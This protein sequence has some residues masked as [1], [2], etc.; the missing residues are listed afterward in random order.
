MTRQTRRRFLSATAGIAGG[1]AGCAGGTRETPDPVPQSASSPESD[2]PYASVY[3]ETIGSVAFVGDESGGGSGFVYRDVVVT[4]QHVV[5]DAESIGVRFEN[6]EWREAGVTATDVYA[7][8]AVLSTDV[9]AYATSLPFV[10]TIPRV[11]T[12]VL[13][14]GSPFGLES[15][16]S[17]GIISGRNRSVP[18]EQ[19][20]F[21]IPNTVQTDA[22]LD[23]GNSGG[24][25]VT[26]EGAVTGINVAGAGTS[27]G[28]AVSP[29]LARRVLPELIETGEYDH[30][31]LG[32]RLI[33]V[34]P[35]VAEA[36]G[37]EEARG[38]FVVETTD[39]APAG[40]TLQGAS[41]E[42]TV[43]GVTVPV[44][45][46]VIVGLAGTRI[47]S[48]ADLGTTLALELSPGD[49]VEATIIRDGERQTVRVEIGARPDP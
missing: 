46:D 9:P 10:D 41:E 23:P 1:L 33:E 22:G 13:A 5:R 20:G 27:V 31:F 47:D 15:S 35:N 12:E 7:D 11:G 6:G 42:T 32:I 45:G 17:A 40:E 28:F 37:L 43:E 36:N 30:P 19:T 44:G 21:P 3:G 34:T 39:E 24:P 38:I 8:L 26:L 2:S 49:L 48:N 16:V 14:L 25:L 4:N 29:L 18:N